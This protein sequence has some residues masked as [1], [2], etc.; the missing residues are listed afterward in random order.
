MTPDDFA[1][2][3]AAK[4]PDLVPIA[5][6]LTEAVRKTWDQRRQTDWLPKVWALVRQQI[7]DQR[8]RMSHLMSDPERMGLVVEAM[9]ATIYRRIRERAGLADGERSSTY[10]PRWIACAEAHGVAPEDLKTWQYLT[11]RET[12][13]D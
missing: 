10:I 12:P 13:T 2:A 6:M 5:P 1:A 9:A 8:E 7:D 3:M 11:W 4:H